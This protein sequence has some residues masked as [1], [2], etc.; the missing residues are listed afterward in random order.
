MCDVLN[1]SWVRQQRFAVALVSCQVGE[2]DQRKRCICRACK[3]GRQK[4]ADQVSSTTA[5]GFRPLPRVSFEVCELADVERI[6]NAE[7][8]HGLL[9]NQATLRK[10]AVISMPL[11]AFLRN[12]PWMIN[13][14]WRALQEAEMNQQSCEHNA[15]G[16]HFRTAGIEILKGVRQLLDMTIQNLTRGAHPEQKK[17]VEYRPE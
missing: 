6:S 12:R 3:L 1:R 10:G 14:D 9:G 7:S 17:P 13:C 2:A 15:A 8:D 11:E 4:V 5:H 16:E